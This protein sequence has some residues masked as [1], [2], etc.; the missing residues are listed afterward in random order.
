MQDNQGIPVELLEHIEQWRSSDLS[1]R[2]Y[3]QRHGLSYDQF[4]YYLKKQL[5][6][7]RRARRRETPGGGFVEVAADLASESNL[8]R[9]ESVEVIR[10][11]GTRI[12]FHGSV[13][14]GFL[15]SL[16]H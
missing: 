12:H 8:M 16:I 9:A 1:R 7:G 3:C 15:K 13:E 14:A 11:D 6:K 5:G 4:Y 2:G 10:P